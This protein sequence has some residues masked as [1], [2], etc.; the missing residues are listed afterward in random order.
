MLRRVK[1]SS[2][3]VTNKLKESYRKAQKEGKGTVAEKMNT[4]FLD[5]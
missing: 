4:E 3:L 2:G 1:I 5:P